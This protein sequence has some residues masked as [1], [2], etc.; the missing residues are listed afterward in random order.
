MEQNYDT[1]TNSKA[2]GSDVSIHTAVI[3][4]IGLGIS[5]TTMSFVFSR[6]ILSIKNI[7]QPN[8]MNG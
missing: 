8:I 2:F 4:G 7:N 6:S 1:S 5:S 3:L